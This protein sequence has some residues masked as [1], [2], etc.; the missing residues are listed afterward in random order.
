MYPLAYICKPLNSARC[1]FVYLTVAVCAQPSHPLR[2]SGSFEETNCMETTEVVFPVKKQVFKLLLSWEFALSDFYWDLHAKRSVSLLCTGL[3][4]MVIEKGTAK[5]AGQQ[6]L[7][8]K[9]KII[10]NLLFLHIFLTF[11]IFRILILHIWKYAV[12]CVPPA[13]FLLLCKPEKIK[14]NQNRINFF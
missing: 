8:L 6:C 12:S 9:I 13:R 5:K 14:T 4:L 3:W 11:N 1:S 2:M 7:K 10:C